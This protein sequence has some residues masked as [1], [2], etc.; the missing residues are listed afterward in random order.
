MSTAFHPRSPSRS[1]SPSSPASPSVQIRSGA[2]RPSSPTSSAAALKCS[3]WYCE[4]SSRGFRARSSERGRPRQA[5]QTAKRSPRRRWTTARITLPVHPWYGEEVAVLRTRGRHAV[6]VERRRRRAHGADRVDESV[7]V[8]AAG[9]RGR[10]A[11]VHLIVD[12]LRSW[13]PGWRHAG[14]AHRRWRAKKLTRD[15]GR[16][17][18]EETGRRTTLR[19]LR[20]DAQTGPAHARPGPRRSATAAAVVGQAGS[21]GRRGGRRGARR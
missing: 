21:P 12:G 19:K 10:G 20:L 6:N 18:E 4:P 2:P 15:R 17:R 7:A 5:N 16:I 9:A 1:G 13:Q 3:L 8:R 11:R 14:A